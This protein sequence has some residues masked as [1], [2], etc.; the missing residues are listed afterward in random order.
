VW[1]EIKGLAKNVFWLEK[2]EVHGRFGELRPSRP[3]AAG[4]GRPIL[5]SVTKNR[6]LGGRLGPPNQ[7][8]RTERNVE[9]LTTVS[10]YTKRV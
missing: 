7:K 10:M 1:K 4:V 5:R 3:I 9:R 8:E 2:G 6:V